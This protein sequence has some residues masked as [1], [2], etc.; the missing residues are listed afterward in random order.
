LLGVQ[1]RKKKLMVIGIGRSGLVGKAFAMRLMHLGFNVHVVGETITPA[2]HKDDILIAISGSGETS[3]VVS[4]AS[5]AK[6]VKAKVIALTSH[7]RSALGKLSDL[8]VKIPGR[9]KIAGGRDYFS[10][11]ILGEHEP[12][13]PLGTLFEVST[14]VFLDSL[15]VELMRRLKTT[16]EEMRARHATIE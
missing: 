1:Q 15:V 4:A 2:L 11:Q 10:R 13:V 7:P 12:L 6:K 9:V 5:I 16:E 14:M 3:F 8:I